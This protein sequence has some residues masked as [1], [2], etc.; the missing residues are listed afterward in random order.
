[1]AI[2]SVVVAEEEERVPSSVLKVTTV[3]SATRL[4]AESVIVAII[5]EVLEAV[6]TV[7]GEACSVITLGTP[8]T[9]E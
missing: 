4:K 3:P 7:E 5:V 6:I 1:M 8:E 9:G 2:P